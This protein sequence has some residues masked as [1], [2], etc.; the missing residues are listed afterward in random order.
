MF[1]TS[2]HKSNY[3]LEGAE[4]IRS[5]QSKESEERA[6]EL[7]GRPTLTRKKMP[8]GPGANGWQIR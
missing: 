5:G 2:R 6:K 3:E 8:A 7:S 1:E 4:L